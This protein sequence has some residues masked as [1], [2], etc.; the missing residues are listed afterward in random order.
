MLIIIL[1]SFPKAI[2]RTNERRKRKG[3]S[4]PQLSLKPIQ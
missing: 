2:N 4:S 3:P 1:I